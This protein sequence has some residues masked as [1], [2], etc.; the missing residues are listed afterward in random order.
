[1]HA[2]QSIQK[3]SVVPCFLSGISLWERTRTAAKTLWGERGAEPRQLPP[4][5]HLATPRNRMSCGMVRI[6]CIRSWRLSLASSNSDNCFWNPTLADPGA[7]RVS[8]VSA[9][10]SFCLNLYRLPDYLCSFP[11]P[12]DGVCPSVINPLETY[13]TSE[14]PETI[15]FD[16][17]SLE[18]NL[19]L[20]VLHSISRYW[21]YL[22][23]V[24]P[25]SKALQE[26]IVQD[27]SSVYNLDLWEA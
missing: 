10:K 6:W 4:K 16:D 22:Y 14:P 23:D 19:L 5:L 12:A 7:F 21:F 2:H 26:I 24:S 8:D 17:P 27:Q 25:L 18:V 13:L 15:T 9:R 3:Q 20:R 11:S 1:M